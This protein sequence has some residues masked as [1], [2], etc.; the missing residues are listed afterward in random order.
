MH[1]SWHNGTEKKNHAH[2]A[3]AG[4]TPCILLEWNGHQHL[5][6]LLDQLT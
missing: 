5:E 2:H 1:V 3:P 4:G 6:L